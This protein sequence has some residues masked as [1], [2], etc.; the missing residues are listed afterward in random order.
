M[1]ILYLTTVLPNR[2]S[3]GELATESF[4]NGLNA[5]GCNVTVLG[6]RRTDDPRGQDNNHV[7]I[8]VRHIETSSARLHSLYWMFQS[9]LRRVPYS[10]QKFYSERYVSVVHEL[11]NKNRYAAIIL[12]HSQLGWLCSH[13]PSSY[14]IIFNTHNVENEIYREHAENSTGLKKLIYR[15]EASLMKEMEGRLSARARQIWTLTTND[16]AYFA[17]MA[18]E[19]KV[20]VFSVSSVQ[21]GTALKTAHVPKSYDVG[22]IGTWTW[23][24]NLDGLVWF[25][26][27][28]YPLLPVQLSI[29]IAGKGA[30]WLLGKYPNVEYC[31]FVPSAEQFMAAA[32]VVAI[33]SVSGGG[34]QIKTL[35]AIASGASIVATS[36]ALRG[37]SEYPDDIVIA[38]DAATF[39]RSISLITSCV[40]PNSS[41]GSREWAEKRNHTFQCELYNAV[42]DLL[43]VATK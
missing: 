23:Q 31:G 38:D 40:S 5:C 42:T 43:N 11:L 29:R 36:F 19:E 4:I 24:A 34:I 33:P 26:E 28:V 2:K 6:Y 25:F 18:S 3:G 10:A 21:M 22:I 9:I 15:R 17:R 16:A 32:R 41:S 27:K 39:S 14:P 35:D 1:K 13:I 12:D 30:D 7:T 37:I 20:R 8:A